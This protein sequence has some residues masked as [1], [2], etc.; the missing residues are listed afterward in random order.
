[1]GSVH[2]VLARSVF[3]VD[4]TFA[5]LTSIMSSRE[6]AQIHNPDI[7]MQTQDLHKQSL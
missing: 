2:L 3:T 6:A 1:M 7:K 5:P 4:L